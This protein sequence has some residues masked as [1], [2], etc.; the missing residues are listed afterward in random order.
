MSTHHPWRPLPG[1]TPL[2]S[3]MATGDHKCKWPLGED[4]PWQFCGQPTTEGKPY[5]PTHCTIAYRPIDP[6]LRLRPPKGA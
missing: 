5:C 1:T 6:K 3:L 2:T 4:T